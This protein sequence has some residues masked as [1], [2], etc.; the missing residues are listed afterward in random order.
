VEVGDEQIY[1][2]RF[3]GPSERVKVVGIEKRKQSI[4]PTSSFSTARR[5]GGVRTYPAR[6]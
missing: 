5:P 1:R 4:E 6:D 3:Y 2:A